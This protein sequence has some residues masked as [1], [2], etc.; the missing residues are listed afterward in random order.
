MIVVLHDRNSDNSP[1]RY[2]INISKTIVDIAREIPKV[3]VLAFL[4]D[5]LKSKSYNFLALQIGYEIL[6]WHIQ[7][8][9]RTEI[10]FA[11]AVC[12]F[13]W[14]AQFANFEP[15]SNDLFIF[16]V[17]VVLPKPINGSIR[18]IIIAI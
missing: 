14:L 9:I 2:R 18:G 3:F 11:T 15:E 7:L 12:H 8:A 16:E 4:F 10:F 6:I 5:C 17:L 13:R 1:W